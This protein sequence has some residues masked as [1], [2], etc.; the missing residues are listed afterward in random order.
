MKNSNNGSHSKQAPRAN[1]SETRRTLRRAASRWIAAWREQV[2]RDPARFRRRLRL[3][4]HDQQLFGDVI[5]PWQE[6]DFAALDD[7]WRRVAALEDGMLVQP[8]RRY[9]RAWIERPRGHSKTSDMAVQIAWVLLAAR[10]PLRGVCAAADCDQAALVLEAVRRLIGANPGLRGELRVRSRAV[11]SR[12][13]A[14][15][16]ELISSDIGSSFGLTPD[17][18]ICDELSH[19]PRE[20]LWHSLLSSAAKRPDCVLTVLTNAGVGRD[21]QW[22]AREAAREHPDW[23]FSSLNG[24]CAPWISPADLEEQR[25][26]LPEPVYDRLW[27][28][29]WQAATGDYLSIEEVAACRDV[30]LAPQKN[31]RIGVRYIAAIDY[32]EKHDRTAAVLMHWENG[33]FVIDRLDLA[34]P[35]PGN[36]VLVSWVEDWIESIAARFPNVA[37]ILDEHQLLGIFQRLRP[38]HRLVRFPFAGGKGNHELAITLRQLI[39][40]RQIAWYPGCG[41]I[42]GVAGDDLES[43]LASLLLKQSAGGRIRFDAPTGGHDDR[44]FVVAAAAWHG[45]SQAS[46]QPRWRVASGRGGVLA[47]GT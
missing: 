38:R 34:V 22:R 12:D 2:R 17:F 46:D 1:A 36:P 29:R 44:A 27:N 18:V 13:G 47:W 28:N 31:A 21:W 26:I 20:G 35:A 30:H 40:H 41:A 39:V 11:E 33:R 6:T 7:G 9:R 4:V 32:A 24:A 14:A 16:M 10:R 45:Q 3:D 37:F 19:W 43:E 23:Y 8:A 5:Q 15:R 25:S 42:V